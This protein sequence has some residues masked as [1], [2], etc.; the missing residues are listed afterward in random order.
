MIK[1]WEIVPIGLIVG[2]LLCLLWSTLNGGAF[3]TGACSQPRAIPYLRSLEQEPHR[4]SAG[5]YY[6]N[7]DGNKS[8]WIANAAYGLEIHSDSFALSQN[9]KTAIWRA[10]RPYIKERDW[11]AHNAHLTD[12]ES[13]TPGNNDAKEAG[14]TMDDKS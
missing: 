14:K 7:L 8:I 6:L 12:N 3:V 10:A 4:W 2:T 11:G 1:S 13:G 5:R 9:C